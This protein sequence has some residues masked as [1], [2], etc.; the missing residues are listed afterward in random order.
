MCTPRT[1]LAL[2]PEHFDLALPKNIGSL[3]MQDMP[4][5]PL[6]QITNGFGYPIHALKF[7][8]EHRLFGYAAG[9]IV[10]NIVLFTA[11]IVLWFGWVWPMFADFDGGSWS[12]GGGAISDVFQ[13]TINFVVRTAGVL[14]GLVLSAIVI[15]ILGQAIASPFLDRLSERIEQIKLGTPEQP[16][17]L[18]LTIRG[19]VMAVADV[20]WALLL[21]VVVQVGIWALSGWWM[22]PLAS[23]LSYLAAAFVVAHEFLTLPLSRQLVPYRTRLKITWAH[24]WWSFGFGGAALLLLWVPFLNLILLPAAAAGGTLLYCDLKAAGRLE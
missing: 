16:F 8:K 13:G 11:F 20:F 9:A 18:P 15:L 5:N 6:S 3:A 24:K 7:M 19:V 2:L 10:V 1:L 23:F 21:L 4:T 14:T 17:S 12:D 22:P